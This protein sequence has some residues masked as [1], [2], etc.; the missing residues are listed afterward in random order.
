MEPS[1][2]AESEHAGQRRLADARFATDQHQPALPLNAGLSQH[3]G[4]LA[5]FL[6]PSHEPRG[7]AT[8]LQPSRERNLRALL[9]GDR[10]PP[11]LDRGDRIGQALQLQG[12]DRHEL[13]FRGRPATSR[14]QRSVARI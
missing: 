1:A 7:A 12:P 4:E 13:D 9:I 3:L 14:T 5:E 2:Y 11:D 10:L 6:G 8:C